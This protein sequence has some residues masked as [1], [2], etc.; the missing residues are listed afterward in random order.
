MNRL[1]KRQI[2]RHFGG[3]DNLPEDLL[4]LFEAISRSYDHY[5]E[6]RLLLE[7]AMD[8]SSEELMAVNKQLRA[9]AKIQNEIFEKLKT[10]LNT[11]IS[12][13]YNATIID[14]PEDILAVVDIMEDQLQRIKEAEGESA[15]LIEQLSDVNEELENFAHIVSHDLKAPLRGITQVAG[16]LLDD[17]ADDLSFMISQK[18]QDEMQYP[19]QIKVT[20]IREKR[21]I[22]F[23][24]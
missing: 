24:R 11:L 20:V 15:E 22:S 12:I 13:S 23:A 5:E 17:Y 6:D 14:E 18:I 8:I 10:S 4:P 2:K 7:R 21:A 19:G 16:W 1:L 9:E 3:V